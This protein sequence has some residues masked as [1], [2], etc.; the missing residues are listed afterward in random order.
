MFNTQFPQSDYGSMLKRR[1][2]QVVFCPSVVIAMQ[3]AL[4]NRFDVQ[5]IATGNGGYRVKGK[6]K[7]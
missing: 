5:A 3:A 6:T 7:L 2:H 4:N 1:R